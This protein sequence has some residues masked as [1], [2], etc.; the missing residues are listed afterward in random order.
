MKL[1]RATVMSILLSIGADAE[2]IDGYTFILDGKPLD[3]G[4]IYVNGE[5]L[6]HGDIVYIERMPLCLDEPGVYEF[7]LKEGIVRRTLKNGQSQIVA[8]EISSKYDE[9]VPVEKW[10]IINPLAGMDDAALKMLRGVTISIWSDEIGKQLGKLDLNHVCLSLQMNWASDDLRVPL[11]PEG[12]R[13]LI[14][15]DGGGGWF[16]DKSRFL[17]L[18]KVRFLSLKGT[19]PLEFDFSILKGMPLEYLSL[20]W[21]D[22]PKNVDVLG[23]F[24]ELKTLAA[25][26]CSFIGDGRWLGKLTNLRTLYA[27]HLEPSL[28][29]DMT[30]TALD[31]AALAGLTKLEAFHVQST[32]V[33]SLPASRMPSLKQA[34]LLRSNAP[35]EMVDAFARANPQATISRSMNAQLAAELAKADRVLVRTGGVSH[36]PPSVEKTIHESRDHG[37]ITELAAHFTVDES[38]SGGYCMCGGNPTFE[39]YRNDKLVAMIAFHHGRSIRWADGTWPGDGMLTEQSSSYLVDWLAKQHFTGPQTEL[40]EGR[41]RAAALQRRNDRYQ[42]LLPPVVWNALVELDDFGELTAVFE[43]NVPDVKTRALLYLMLFGCEDSTWALSAGMDQSL[44]GTWLP[45]IP[46]A[47]LRELI[48]AAPPKSEEGLG[49]IRWVFGEGHVDV[50][51]DDEAVLKTLAQFALTH[52]RQSNRWRT[53]SVLRDLGTP[54]A[55]D[56]L[57]TVMREGTNPRELGEDQAAE[58]GGQMT[59]HPGAITLPDGTPDQIAAALCLALIDDEASRPDIKTLRDGL[60]VEV[61]REWDKSISRKQK[62]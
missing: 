41:R 40:F 31:L 27:S 1:I 18:K 49:A 2:T 21:T 50:V 28:G 11:L 51:K 34:S 57:R 46:A 13:T 4:V 5:V 39:F 9:G 7:Q 22:N 45:G 25:N 59:F 24:T 23:T 35:A 26:H 48:L 30:V 47:T 29:E 54:V 58:P 15:E 14:F 16:Q 36:G 20:P 44:I 38:E 3:P 8:C 32:P 6:S 53:L 37:V 61:S 62:R 10:P 42:A 52:P 43:K 33:K 60:S 55:L 17:R 19:S 56:L 12:V